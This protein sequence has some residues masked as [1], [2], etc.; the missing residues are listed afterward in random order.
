VIPRKWIKCAQHLPS[1]AK[2]LFDVV[3]ET[4]NISANVGNAKY[5]EIQKA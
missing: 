1:L 3:E 5:V 2:L 4:A